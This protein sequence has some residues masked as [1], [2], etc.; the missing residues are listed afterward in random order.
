[1][2]FC[3]SCYGVK[4]R[5]SDCTSLHLFVRVSAYPS[6]N[7]FVHSSVSLS[8][9]SFRYPLIRLFIGPSVYV[10]FCLSF[11]P[12]IRR[13]ICFSPFINPSVPPSFSILPSSLFTRPSFHPCEC[14][15]PCVRSSGSPVRLFLFPR[16]AV[17]SVGEKW[18]DERVAIAGQTGVRGRP[19]RLVR[20]AFLP[21]TRRS[22][23][24]DHKVASVFSFLSRF[25]KE[26]ML[27][28]MN[29][30]FLCIALFS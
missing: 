13:S 9:V 24:Y 4:I 21:T 18:P 10:I 25:W 17:L 5:P 27:L 8:A 1:M 22:F 14:P 15:C 3:S 6:V 26:K 12:Y 16:A 20:L 28:L 7:L 11:L 29:R 2:N 19:S 30:F 23:C